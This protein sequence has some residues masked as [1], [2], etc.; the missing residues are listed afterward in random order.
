MNTI[1]G[2]IPCQTAS[3]HSNGQVESRFST[4]QIGH[5]W[6]PEKAGSGLDRV[7]FS[8][9]KHLPDAGVDIQGLVA[10][11]PSPSEATLSEDSS[12]TSVCSARASLPVRLASFRRSCHT[13]FKHGGFDL[14]ASHFPLFAFPT[15]GTFDTPLVT[16]FHGPWA[17]EG[18]V[19]G[20]G[21]AT[22][23][24][25][26]W[27]ETRVYR[28]TARF[29]V[30]SEAF[31][32]V[33]IQQY[34]VPPERISIVPG[35]VD[36][37]RFQPTLTRHAA[38]KKLGW[39]TGRPILLSVRRLVRRVGLDRLVDAVDLARQ[40]C[41]DLLLHIAGT[42]PLESDLRRQIDDLGLGNHVKLL[43]FVPD[44]DL[45]T[46]YRAATISIVPT[47]A[48]E[49]FGLV[50]VE[51]LAAGTPAL[52]TP[53]G[54]LPEVVCDLSESLITESAS[55]KHIAARILDVVDG[56]VSVPTANACTAFARSHYSW[57]SVAQKTRTVYEDA[58]S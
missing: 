48:L 3:R 9:C 32:T 57:Q 16:H 18:S 17:E 47:I 8:L 56:T 13:M 12:I 7:Y 24:V 28:N 21:F 46:A 19:E 54:G 44:D 35:G 31:R 30:L 20:D 40:C 11:N 53:V 14:V 43:G 25:K 52:V 26:R 27:I 38:R 49:G 55:I 37:G 23:R 58:L 41:P 50:A 2:E 15:L 34:R 22:S 1:R 33:L 5:G 10:G 36:V 45:P 6:K 39:P 51:S 42:G 4:L 29:I